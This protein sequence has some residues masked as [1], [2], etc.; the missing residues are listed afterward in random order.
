M[1]IKKYFKI[2]YSAVKDNTSGVTVII[3]P[4]GAIAG[5]CNMGAAPASI[6][7]DLLKD[8]NTVTSIHACV[9][10]GCSAFGLAASCGVRSFLRDQKIGLKVNNCIVPI[11]VG[12]SIFTLVDKTEHYVNETTGYMAASQAKENNY[13]TGRIG[14]SLGA[15]VSKIL[16]TKNSSNTQQSIVEYFDKKTG[17]EVMVIS[18]VNAFGDIIS[19]DGKNLTKP[20]NLTT[21]EILMNG[22]YKD[23]DLTSNTTISCILT[24][25]KLDKSECNR[26]ARVSHDAYA[27]AIKPC[28]TALDGD[29]IFVLTSN[30]VDCN[31]MRLETIVQ[32]CLQDAI[33]NSVI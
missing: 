30:S 28:H 20:S 31:T 10:S 9:L 29:S 12:A 25:A 33:V 5:Y 1:E 6:E 4:K 8:G 22:S 24:N 15:S 17:L 26:I 18:I 23:Q 13:T 27:R 21:S 2:G 16:S 32:D 19:R 7:T 14:A 3:A 11:V